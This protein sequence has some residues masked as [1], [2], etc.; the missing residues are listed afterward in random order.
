MIFDCFLFFN[1]EDLLD[2]RLNELSGAV[3]KFVIIE[4]HQTFAGHDR[5]L[6]FPLIEDKFSEF[7]DQIIYASVQMPYGKENSRFANRAREIHQR[8]HIK[9]VLK[10]NGVKDEDRV[11]IS[12]LDEIPDKDYLLQ[13]TQ[14][15]QNYVFLQDAFY[16]YVNNRYIAA[17]NSKWYG[18]ISVKWEHLKTIKPSSPTDLTFIISK[19]QDYIP[20]EAGWHFSY[21][22]GAEAIKNK[23]LSFSAADEYGSSSS[24]NSLESRFQNNQDL[25]GR[26]EIQFRPISLGDIKYPDYLLNNQE[27]FHHLIL[28]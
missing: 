4:A 24:L 28:S 20:I 8:E 10:D 17:G 22:G 2:L 12:D 18:T 27:K 6:V 23:V 26:P 9:T 1:E 16:Y 5:D 25:F 14:D 21:L 7:K 13:A 3:D 19:K 11:L 15:T